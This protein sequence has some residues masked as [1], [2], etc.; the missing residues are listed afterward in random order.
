VDSPEVVTVEVRPGR[1]F[2]AMSATV[3]VIAA[4]GVALAVLAADDG[5]PSDA[6]PGPTAPADEPACG[7]I[8]LLFTA[9]EVE[10]LVAPDGTRVRVTIP[11]RP[12]AIVS[13]PARRVDLRGEATEGIVLPHG[14]GL[15]WLRLNGV[16]VRGPTGL[17]IPCESF[18]V[19]V[20]DGP[21]GRDGTTALAV[22]VATELAFG[23]DG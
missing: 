22:D 9:A 20:L 2:L 5:P 17:P 19:A 14:R 3:A 15:L 13:V 11:G 12:E 4:A 18:E 8:A 16:T 1:G 7:R 6:A 21:I 23:V 10:P